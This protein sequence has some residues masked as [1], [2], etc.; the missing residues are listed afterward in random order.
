[1]GCP[2]PGCLLGELQPRQEVFLGTQQGHLLEDAL[3][4]LGEHQLHQHGEGSR[5]HVQAGS[6][7]EVFLQVVKGTC[8][9]GE[10]AGSSRACKPGGF[11]A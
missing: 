6:V 8:T 2:Y 3:L 5:A 10:A 9:R 1:M 11:G 7:G 4:D